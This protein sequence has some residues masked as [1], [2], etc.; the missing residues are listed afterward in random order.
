MKMK[1]FRRVIKEPI[2]KELLSRQLYI[3]WV[4]EIDTLV[5]HH[6]GVQDNPD[7]KEKSS[8]HADV[9]ACFASKPICKFCVNRYRRL[10]VESNNAP[11]DSDED[12][13]SKPHCIRK[14]P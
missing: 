12:V 14:I 10:L 9:E 3:K 2:K 4:E 7:C 13:A 11:S 1:D 6:K 5:A 8:F